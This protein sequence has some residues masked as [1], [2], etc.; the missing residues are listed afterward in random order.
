MADRF[1]KLTN[2]ITDIPTICNPIKTGT[3]ENGFWWV[4]FSIDTSNPLAWNVIQVFAYVINYLSISERLSTVFYPVAQPPFSADSM[5]ECLEWIIE[6][7][8]Q[9]FLPNEL[10]EWLENRLP[11][12]SNHEE[13]K[14][15]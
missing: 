5:Q 2:L 3:H 12:P 9:D 8:S 7:T 4:K 1:F 10:A 11:D 13:W 6:S 15:K 14:L